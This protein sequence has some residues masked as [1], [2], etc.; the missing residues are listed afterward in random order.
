MPYS[1]T[2]GS[3][4]PTT[5]A[6]TPSG[7]GGG[8]TGGSY[9]PSA[10]YNDIITLSGRIYT[11]ELYEMNYIP[12]NYNIGTTTSLPY[13]DLPTVSITYDLNQNLYYNFGLV[14]G[15]PGAVGPAGKDGTPPTEKTIIQSIIAWVSGQALNLAIDALL[16]AFGATT[17]AG[18]QTQIEYLDGVTF[19]LRN[20]LTIAEQSIIELEANVATMASQIE[21]MQGQIESIQAKVA[22][23]SCIPEHTS[24]T[25][26]LTVYTP[27][28]TSVIWGSLQI[29]GNLTIANQNVGIDG[30]VQFP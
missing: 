4:K 13:G 9:T 26:P 8:T 11:V 23:I 21:F 17:I 6:P 18:I 7:G 5:V 2:G 30:L 1:L 25:S 3:P 14:E 24:I 27:L 29:N 19:E 10:S 28:E 15:A 16:T 22:Y 12:L 20:E